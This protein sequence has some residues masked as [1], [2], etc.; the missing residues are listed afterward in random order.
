MRIGT[1][2]APYD[3]SV[4]QKY[5]KNIELSDKIRTDTLFIYYEHGF[6]PQRERR[7]ESDPPSADAETCT[8]VGLRRSLASHGVLGPLIASTV[9]KPIS[10]NLEHRLR[11][12]QDRRADRRRW[13]SLAADRSPDRS[14]R[15]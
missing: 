14:A 4:R 15:A 8:L 1:L 3:N 6:A 2:Y 7:P 5:T 9:L 11:T 12:D 10:D 13:V